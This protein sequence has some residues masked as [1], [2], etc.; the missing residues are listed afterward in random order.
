MTAGL[1]EA[2]VRCS[3]KKDAWLLQRRDF[4]GH[5]YIYIHVYVYVYVL[6]LLLL[7]VVVVVV[8]ETKTAAPSL[9]FDPPKTTSQ[10]VLSPVVVV[11]VLVLV[12]V[13]LV[14]VS[15]SSSSSRIRSAK[16]L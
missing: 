11:F 13:V 1:T 14:A 2:T 7:L 10:Q 4:G 12:L 8:V 16:P 6:L 3:C 9:F 5:I 15:S